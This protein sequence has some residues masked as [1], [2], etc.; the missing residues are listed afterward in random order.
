MREID[1]SQFHNAKTTN[2]ILQCKRCGVTFHFN[3]DDIIHK[4]YL[5]RRIPFYK[6]SFV[7]CPYCG[8]KLLFWVCKFSLN[9]V[10]YIVEE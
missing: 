2:F 5:L 4:K 9:N 6:K 8:K 3:G 10:D 1:K 7:K